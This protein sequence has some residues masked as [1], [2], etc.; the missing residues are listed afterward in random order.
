MVKSK[1]IFMLHN[2]RRHRRRLHPQYEPAKQEDIMGKVDKVIFYA[3][4]VSQPDS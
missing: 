4:E 1:W 3:N 2:N